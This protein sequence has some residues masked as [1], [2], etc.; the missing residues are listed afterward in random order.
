MEELV[1]KQ[2]VAIGSLLFQAS[3]ILGFVVW[4]IYIFPATWPSGSIP[5][6][7]GL[8]IIFISPGLFP[9]LLA[10]ELYRGKLHR[11][12]LQGWAGTCISFGLFYLLVMVRSLPDFEI[13]RIAM[14]MTVLFLLV[15]SGLVLR[16]TG[17]ST[18]K[19]FPPSRQ[20]PNPFEGDEQG[21]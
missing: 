13:Y 4:T 10:I 3:V 2:K 18:W 9:L 19:W 16:L 21:G 17:L 11:R 8:Y 20:A 15:P 12:W 5:G 14:I 6:I 1:S 7:I